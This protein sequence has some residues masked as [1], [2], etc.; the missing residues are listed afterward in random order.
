[1]TLLAKA[2]LIRAI[3]LASPV[4]A[5]AI[6]A[7]RD[8]REP[9]HLEKMRL[10]RRL[11]RLLK[12]RFVRQF[13]NLRRILEMLTGRKAIIDPAWIQMALEDNDAFFEAQ[14][15]AM[16]QQ[17]ARSGVSLFG[18]DVPIGIDWTLTN[19]EAANWA[20]QYAGQLISKVDATSLQAV[21]SAV[22]QFVETPGMTMG[23]L[24]SLLPFN[25]QRAGMIATTEVT[26]AYAAGQDIAGDRLVKEYPDVQVIDT[27]Y[28]NNDDRVCPLCGPLNGKKVKHGDSFATNPKTGQP[29]YRPPYHVRCRCWKASS[30]NI[31]GI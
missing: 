8:P 6:K 1:M 14:L 2:N 22:A 29:I 27:W 28:T 21:Q 3:S 17:A 5:T 16:V 20:R 10:E 24:R 12:Y 31:R 26:S 23:D 11:T 13:N 4:L 30:T 19:S 18:V 25:E 9:K 7:G 15:L